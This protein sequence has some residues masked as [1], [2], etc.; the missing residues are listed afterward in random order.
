MVYD[1]A[2]RRT[3]LYGGWLPRLHLADTWD[4]DGV[5]WARVL[6]DASPPGRWGFAMAYDVAC[7]RVVLFGGAS[8]D[9]VSSDTWVFGALRP[10]NATA[11]GTPCPGANGPPVLSSGT[12]YLGNSAFRLDL[13]AGRASSP[14]A[15]AFAAQSDRLALGGGCTLYLRGSIASFG[16]A[17]DA[18]GFAAGPVIPL[19]ADVALRG[20]TVYAQA[21]VVDPRGPVLGLAFSAGCTIVFGD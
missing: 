9:G 12:P 19:P 5:D 16:A 18:V 3:V 20:L 21:F 14:C 17:T 1:E 15:F 7:E 2:R 8:H 4:W 6:P 13:H 11:L 10:A